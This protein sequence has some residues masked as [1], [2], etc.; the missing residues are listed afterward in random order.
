MRP[1]PVSESLEEAVQRIFIGQV[2]LQFTNAMMPLAGKHSTTGLTSI[3]SGIHRQDHTKPLT[4]RYD[5]RE[6][7]AAFGDR[8]CSNAAFSAIPEIGTPED[9]VQPRIKNPKPLV[10]AHQ[11]PPWFALCRTEKLLEAWFLGQRVDMQHLPQ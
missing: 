3:A 5:A 1:E 4:A 11:K 7:L 8:S 6:D 10:E 2:D 9:V